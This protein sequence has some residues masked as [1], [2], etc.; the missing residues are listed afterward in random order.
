M[1][2]VEFKSPNSPRVE[3]EMVALRTRWGPVTRIDAVFVE[4]LS[5]VVVRGFQKVEA[6]FLSATMT[7]VD[8]KV[9]VVTPDG[10]PVIC[11]VP[12][13]IFA[14]I[15]DPATTGAELLGLLKIASILCPA[16]A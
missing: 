13:A 16:S 9:M 2:V 8:P 6:V 3:P 4:G 10:E 5:D 15:D 1:E 7:T 14:A 11:T 12:F